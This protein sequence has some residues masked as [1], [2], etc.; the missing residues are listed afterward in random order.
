MNIYYATHDSFDRRW[1]LGE[2]G[3]EKGLI[4]AADD[5]YTLV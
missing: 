3:G 1:N 4:I 2:K 5:S